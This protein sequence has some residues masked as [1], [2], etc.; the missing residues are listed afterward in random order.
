AEEVRHRSARQ[1]EESR[2]EPEVVTGRSI[3]P[4]TSRSLTSSS[5]SFTRASAGA[6]LSGS[7][8]RS[9]V[10]RSRRRRRSATITMRIDIQS[11]GFYSAATSGVRARRLS[12]TK[13][14]SNRSS[15]LEIET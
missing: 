4:P 7:V 1:R 11:T 12:Q 6:A 10:T 9:A 8:L 2:I 3:A 5:R 14:I 13:R 15:S